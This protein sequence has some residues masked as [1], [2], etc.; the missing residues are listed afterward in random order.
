MTTCFL[1]TAPKGMQPYGAV[2]ER[3]KTC[4]SESRHAQADLRAGKEAPRAA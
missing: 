3:S 1:N 2:V 4:E